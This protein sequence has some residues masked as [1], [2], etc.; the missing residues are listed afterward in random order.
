[1][2]FILIFLLVIF[3]GVFFFDLF[4]RKYK[5]PYQFN[6]VIGSPGAGKST[7]YCKL[8]HYYLS[9]GYHV[10]GT[11]PVQIVIKD[12]KTREKTVVQVKEIDAKHLYRY[13]FPEDSVILL[14]ELGTVFHNRAWKEFNKENVLF[15]KHFRHCHLIVWGWSQS[16]DI[17]LTLRNLVSQFWIQERKMRIFSVA[18]RLVMKPVVVHP[19]G[20]GVARI[21]DDFV[22]DPKLLKP[23][24]G[25]MKVIF[26]PRW[27]KN[28]DSYVIP[29]KMAQNMDIDFSVDPVPY[30]RPVPKRVLLLRAR[31]IAFIAK[32]RE[33]V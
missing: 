24:V 22:E 7:M 20:E 8:A 26:I 27:V 17:D 6:M 31:R 33:R 3:L 11:D 4:T 15:W 23:V 12:K 14:D 25:G 1:M 16:F 5:Q 13:R 21:T 9:R 10:Y 2:K 32:W 18:R 28:F 19:Q 29:E 30:V